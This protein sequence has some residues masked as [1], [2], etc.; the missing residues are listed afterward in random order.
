MAPRTRLII[1]FLLL[2]VVPLSAVTFFTYCSWITTFEAAAQRE[3]AQ[4]AMDIGRRMERITADVGRRMDRLFVADLDRDIDETTPGAVYLTLFVG[5]LDA[6][7][8]ELRYV[9]AGHNPQFVLHH[10]GGIEPMGATGLPIAL[11]PGQ[12]YAEARRPVRPGDLIF[13]YTD[14]LVE[15][16]NAAG[17]RFGADRLQALLVAQQP[18]GIDAVLEGVEDALRQF[19]GSTEPFDDATMMAPGRLAGLVRRR[20]STTGCYATNV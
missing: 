15:M 9:N 14:G 19:R 12:P 3:A 13:F 6:R 7:R 4:S 1:A 11:Y 5:V 18:N 20:T 8:Q 17:E 10:E 2:S 16:E